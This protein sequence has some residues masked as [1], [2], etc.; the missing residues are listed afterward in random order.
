MKVASPRGLSRVGPL[1]ALIFAGLLPT[2]AGAQQG[3][4]PIVVD[5]GTGDN[6]LEAP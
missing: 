1:L 2:S 4:V 6:W 3:P 5:S